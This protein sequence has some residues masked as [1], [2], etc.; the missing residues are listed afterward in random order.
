MLCQIEFGH[1]VHAV[2]KKQME[3]KK[4][5]QNL[6]GEIRI[7]QSLN[8]TATS[9]EVQDVNLVNHVRRSKITSNLRTFL[10]LIN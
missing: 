3:K 8:R 5:T 4:L 2:K 7:R 9:V 1:S 6:D 10:R